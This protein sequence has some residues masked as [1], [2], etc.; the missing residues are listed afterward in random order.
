MEF[1]VNY[2]RHKRLPL[3]SFYKPFY[4]NL[5]A[6]NQCPTVVTKSC[7]WILLQSILFEFA[8]P[9]SV[10]YCR[11]KILSLNFT[12]FYSNLRDHVPCATVVT[13]SCHWILLHSILFEFACPH[14]VSYCRHKILSLNFTPF[15][16]NLRA[17]SQCPTVV[18]KSCHWIFTS[19]SSNLNAHILCPTVVT[20][21][22]H[23]IFYVILFE[24][25]L[26]QSVFRRSVLVLLFPSTQFRC[27]R[28]SFILI[29]N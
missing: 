9:H 12:P 22:C 23:W 18:T 16:S 3:S 7:H 2:R 13:K 1:E 20:N 11:H 19:F 6:H 29:S 24:F 21:S 5:Y 15:Y 17:H 27:T 26:P 14:S 8:C 4:S 10:S 25:T 28:V